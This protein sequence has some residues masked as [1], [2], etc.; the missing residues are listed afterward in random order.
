[1]SKKGDRR[2][3]K[4]GDR[5]VIVGLY[6]RPNAEV[7]IDQPRSDN[8]VHV[9]EA[10]DQ[11]RYLNEKDLVRTEEY[12]AWLTENDKKKKEETEQDAVTSMIDRYKNAVADFLSVK[13]LP[14]KGKERTVILREAYQYG[15]SVVPEAQPY[16]TA[17]MSFRRRKL[18]EGKL[19]KKL[20]RRPPTF[21][22]TAKERIGELLITSG[23]TLVARITRDQ[24]RSEYARKVQ[25][26]AVE[27][28]QPVVSPGVIAT[29]QDEE[30]PLEIVEDG[31]L[32]GLNVTIQVTPKQK[33]GKELLEEWVGKSRDGLSA[34]VPNFDVIQHFCGISKEEYIQV[35]VEQS[36]KGVRFIALGPIGYSVVSPV[37]PVEYFASLSLDQVKD[38]L[39]KTLLDSKEKAGQ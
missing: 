31:V 19:A 3:F 21:T 2:L 9:R 4:K 8:R 25:E 1:M 18:R 33:S 28:E 39:I 14:S 13:P 7:M 36:N 5:V 38:L 12:E 30:K 35:F 34:F 26:E 11:R 16:Y 6:H 32:D 17:G 37:D 27:K 20:N 29:V 23:S 10:N 22:P 15:L 24:K